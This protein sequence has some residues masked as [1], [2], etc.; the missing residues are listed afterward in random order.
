M[1]SE[2]KEKVDALW[3]FVVA[4]IEAAMEPGGALADTGNPVR[5]FSASRGFYG[6]PQYPAIAVSDKRLLPEAFTT[7]RSYTAL[8]TGFAVMER[9][10]D[11][12]RGQETVEAL[13]HN[14]AELFQEADDW[15]DVADDLSV[16]SIDYQPLGPGGE[17]LSRPTAEVRLIWRFEYLHT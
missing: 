7:S 2:L 12:D 10:F 3:A 8:E 15:H 5:T 9:D 1:A 16:E 4:K 14:L 13:A 11:I 17:A 6:T